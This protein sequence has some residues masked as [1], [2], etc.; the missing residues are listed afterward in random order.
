MHNDYSKLIEPSYLLCVKMRN[1][2]DFKHF[3]DRF[4][5]ILKLKLFKHRKKKTSVFNHHKGT[6]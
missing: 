4:I 1:K 2:C 5:L 6:L 3:L